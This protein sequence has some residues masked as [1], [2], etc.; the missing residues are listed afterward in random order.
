MLPVEEVFQFIFVILAHISE[1]CPDVE[2]VEWSSWILSFW[3]SH[4]ELKVWG[5][6]VF[7]WMAWAGVRAA[8]LI[9]SW[10]GFGLLFFWIR[11]GFIVNLLLFNVKPSHQLIHFLVL[12]PFLVLYLTN[13]SWNLLSISIQALLLATLTG[14]NYT[15]LL[16]LLVVRDFLLVRILW[17]WCFVEIK[18]ILLIVVTDPRFISCLQVL[19]CFARWIDLLLGHQLIVNRLSQ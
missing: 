5:L 6:V 7:N 8:L 10:L 9:H 16:T 15:I 17:L 19:S 11:I 2:E 14:L 13:W 1:A 18:S 3:V 12:G 4:R